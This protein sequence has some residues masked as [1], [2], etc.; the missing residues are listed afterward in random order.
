MLDYPCRLEDLVQREPV[1]I[2][3]LVS[4]K[5]PL[6][7][8]GWLRVAVSQTLPRT[9]DS[10]GLLDYQGA[11][12]S[13]EVVVIALDAEQVPGWKLWVINN[14]PGAQASCFL[15]GEGLIKELPN[16]FHISSSQ[17][18]AVGSLSLLRGE[19]KSVSSPSF[20]FRNPYYEG[21]DR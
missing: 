21:Q 16:I 7:T 5:L 4:S 15:Q 8:T 20:Y 18:A 9:L 2:D 3:G 14:G 17:V 11:E 13:D 10:A 6:D 1:N 19:V 12:K